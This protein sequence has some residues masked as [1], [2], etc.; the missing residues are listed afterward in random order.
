MEDSLRTKHT[1]RCC[2]HASRSRYTG[3]YLAHT[4]ASGCAAVCAACTHGVARPPRQRA[5]ASC[6]PAACRTGRRACAGRR[7]GLAGRGGAGWLGGPRFHTK[8]VHATYAHDGHP[9]EVYTREVRTHTHIQAEAR[10]VESHCIAVGTGAWTP[11]SVQQCAYNSVADGGRLAVPFRAPSAGSRPPDPGSRAHG[12]GGRGALAVGLATRAAKAN[13][14]G[15]GACVLWWRG[16]GRRLGGSCD[17][18]LWWVG[19]VRSG[20]CGSGWCCACCAVLGTGRWYS[21]EH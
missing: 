3:R 16:R 14:V 5:S 7:R 13:G 17:V 10:P 11:S 20:G 9:R 1:H 8:Y 19:A 15:G 2:A 21:T 12:K 4:S 6:Q 18:M